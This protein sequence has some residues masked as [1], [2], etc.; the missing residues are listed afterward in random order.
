M[1]VF[2][3]DLKPQNI[4]VD[5]SNNKDVKLLNFGITRLL[6]DKAIME[7]TGE[8]LG[9]PAYMSPEQFSGEQEIGPAS[10][11]YALGCVLYECLTGHSPYNAKTYIEWSS[12]HR[13]VRVSLEDSQLNLTKFGKDLAVLILR[14][15]DKEPANRPSA[16]ELKKA[17]A[18][19]SL[20]KP[21]E[22]E[23]RMREMAKY[24]PKLLIETLS[25]VVVLIVCGMFAVSY[26]KGEEKEKSRSKVIKQEGNKTQV[27]TTLAAGKATQEIEQRNLTVETG[28]EPLNF[29]LYSPK[30]PAGI[31]IV[32]S[33]AENY[34][35]KALEPLFKTIAERSLLVAEAELPKKSASKNLATIIRS[36]LKE[37]GKDSAFGP[38]PPE[39]FALMTTGLDLDKTL[40]TAAQFTG[41]S[42]ESKTPDLKALIVTDPISE[43]G[44]TPVSVKDLHSFPVPIFTV[45]D[46][47]LDETARP[48]ADRRCK[49]VFAY[50]SARQLF[51]NSSRVSLQK[52]PAY[53]D[54][55]VLMSFMEAFLDINLNHDNA[56]A[57]DLY[58]AQSVQAVS[59][60]ANLRFR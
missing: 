8:A 30:N 40:A 20:P 16:S 33:T 60:V 44:S 48:A 15:L 11:I 36:S 14:C 50:G 13:H 43:T 49:A 1:G 21:G 58:S 34:D 25:S 59:S 32:L 9:T 53:T 22:A 19:L 4:M 45:I 29:R 6:D 12:V 28:A 10:D 3:R 17:L 26:I 52:I 23:K 54:Q 18:E 35:Y 46:A 55:K 27:I 42:V 41:L 24:N 31:V 38:N 2:H 37:L 56:K 51:F 7:E 39:K 57:T 5:N 47:D